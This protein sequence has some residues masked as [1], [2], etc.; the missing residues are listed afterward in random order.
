MKLRAGSLKREAKLI[1]LLPDLS[2][3]KERDPK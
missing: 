2:R 3:E 1:N